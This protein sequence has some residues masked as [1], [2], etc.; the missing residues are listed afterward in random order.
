[1]MIFG[2]IIKLTQFVL[3]KGYLAYIEGLYIKPFY[4]YTFTYTYTY[5][6]TYT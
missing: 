2:G 4:T 3:T 1:M 6:Y 5:T